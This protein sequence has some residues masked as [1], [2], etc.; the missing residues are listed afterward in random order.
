MKQQI[1]IL[2][3]DQSYIYEKTE[4]WRIHRKE[5]T[6]IITDLA[7]VSGIEETAIIQYLR[8]NTL[9]LKSTAYSS[10]TF[11]FSGTVFHYQ[12]KLNILFSK[13]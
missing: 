7:T 6:M 5:F 10:V 13:V 4:L 2:P 11:T 9:V 12:I 3:E 1:T 8:L